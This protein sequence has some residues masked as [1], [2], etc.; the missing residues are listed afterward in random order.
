ML[1]PIGRYHSIP[2]VQDRTSRGSD[3]ISPHPTSS[4]SRFADERNAGVVAF[5]SSESDSE[6]TSSSASRRPLIQLITSAV[7]LSIIATHLAPIDI[8]GDK[9]DHLTEGAAL[10]S[11]YH[12]GF[13]KHELVLQNRQDEVVLR[14]LFHVRGSGQLCVLQDVSSCRGVAATSY[15]LSPATIFLAAGQP[16]V[17][18][19]RFSPSCPSPSF[20]IQRIGVT[21]SFATFLAFHVIREWQDCKIYLSKIRRTGKNETLGLHNLSP[22]PI[23]RI[24]IQVA[25]RLSR[26]SK[27]RK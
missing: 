11:S 20:R 27:R 6:R 12:V 18:H 4:C 21:S 19:D 23:P 16:L 22:S 14:G 3:G 25:T 26:M 9:D 10:S 5:Q 13:F 15:E 24:T 8:R 2:T 17:V 7:C 1:R